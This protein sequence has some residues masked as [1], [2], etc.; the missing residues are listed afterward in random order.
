[1]TAK[2]LLDKFSNQIVARLGQG[3]LGTDAARA[4][5]ASAYPNSHMTPAA[6]S[7]AVENLSG[8]QG[9]TQAKAQFLAPVAAQRDVSAYMAAEQAFDRA[10]DPRVWQYESLA[11]PARKR[12]F[13]QG[14]MKED[15]TFMQRVQKL[16]EMGAI[17]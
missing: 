13:L 2:N 10:A 3:G 12:T 11:D 6:I 15:P 1:M 4:L 9:M 8:A 14:V 17:R 5:L 7:E 16:H